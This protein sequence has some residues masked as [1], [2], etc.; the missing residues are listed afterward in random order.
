MSGCCSAVHDDGED[1]GLPGERQ[2]FVRSE[3]AILCVQCAVDDSPCTGG[4]PAVH[5]T[6][7][8]AEA[9]TLTIVSPQHTLH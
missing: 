1:S 6:L 8:A 4:V 7:S 9:M 5:T 2:S 3:A